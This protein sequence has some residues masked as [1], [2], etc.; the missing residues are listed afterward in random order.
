MRRNK[1]NRDSQKKK[2]AKI[3]LKRLPGIIAK[4]LFQL[5]YF[6][7][8]FL[9]INR[10]L[11]SLASYDTKW[12]GKIPSEDQNT[13]NNNGFFGI[14]SNSFLLVIAEYQKYIIV[15]NLLRRSLDRLQKMWLWHLEA[16]LKC[17]SW[18]QKA[19][20]SNNNQENIVRDKERNAHVKYQWSYAAVDSEQ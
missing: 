10:Y 8:Y 1:L 11:L 5:N 9:L 6:V 12:K 19:K 14:L 2:N 15:F 4:L 17:E 16:N 20:K 7:S 3:T 13:D 18:V